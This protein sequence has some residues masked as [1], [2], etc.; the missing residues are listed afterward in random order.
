MVEEAT[1]LAV[2]GVRRA[3]REPG[4]WLLVVISDGERVPEVIRSLPGVTGVQL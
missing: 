1:L 2:P 3:V 4:G